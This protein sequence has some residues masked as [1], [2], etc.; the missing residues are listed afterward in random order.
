MGIALGVTDPFRHV[1]SR[2]P[3][4]SGSRRLAGP[5][6]AAQLSMASVNPMASCA[7]DTPR[8]SMSN[9]S[10]WHRPPRCRWRWW[11]ATPSP[12]RGNDL[13]WRAARLPVGRCQ[14]H[15]RRADQGND[16]H[17]DM[18]IIHQG[19]RGDE[20]RYGNRHR[21][22]GARSPTFCG[23]DKARRMTPRPR[24]PR[25]LPSCSQGRKAPA[26][27]AV[28]QDE[29]SQHTSSG[30]RADPGEDD[31]GPHLVAGRCIAPP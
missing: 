15:D 11:S 18:E 14:K 21:R 4:Y 19:Q 7:S 30:Q 8:R 24:R 10:T 23:F 27:L 17:G 16:R 1:T 6:N 29:A 12:G 28:R 25:P 9:P 13:R 3:A 20:K 31:G 22:D 5:S 26:Q 2:Q